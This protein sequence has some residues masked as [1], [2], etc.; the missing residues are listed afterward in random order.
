MRIRAFLW[1]VVLLP[2]WTAPASSHKDIDTERSVVTVRVF[3]AGLLSS[4]GHEHEVRA[5]IQK[6]SIDDE[7]NTVE[8]A[9]DAHALRVIDSDISDKDRAEIQSTMLG[10]K[11]LDSEKFHEIRFHSTEVSRASENAWTV[12]G[13][14][15][16]HGQTRRVKVKVE[17]N[18]G[19]Y[20]GS[21]E[22]RQKDFG[23]EPITVAGGSIKVKNEVRIAFVIVAK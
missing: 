15:T 9:V 20:R 16:L 1:I 14:L 21:A 8:F 7:K 22:L 18:D 19:R 3:K 10:P 4:F 23:I 11:V 6:G 2:L 13:D 5:P 12:D 17:R